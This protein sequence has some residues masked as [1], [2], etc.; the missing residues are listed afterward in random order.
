MLTATLLALGSASLH[1]GWN[2]IIKTSDQDRRI[3]T[4]GVFLLAKNHPQTRI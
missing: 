2:L 4:W 3:A 1:A